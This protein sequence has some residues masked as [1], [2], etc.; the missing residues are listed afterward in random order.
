MELVPMVSL[1]YEISQYLVCD[2]VWMIYFAML[3]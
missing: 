3:K 1:V 2:L